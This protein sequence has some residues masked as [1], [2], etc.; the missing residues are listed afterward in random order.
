MG[1]EISSGWSAGRVVGG[2][3]SVRPTSARSSLRIALVGV[4]L[5]SATA[6]G[7]ERVTLENGRSVEGT[8]VRET[9]TR[10]RLRTDRGEFW[11]NKSEIASIE[12]VDEPAKTPAR[13]TTTDAVLLRGTQ[14][15]AKKPAGAEQKAPGSVAAAARQGGA[16]AEDILRDMSSTR[17]AVRRA[18]AYRMVRSWPDSSTTLAAVLEHGSDEARTEATRLLSRPDVGTARE[19]RKLVRQRLR[20]PH[21]AV[22]KLA[23]RAVGARKHSRLEA[24][25]LQLLD[26]DPDEAVR[27]EA[28]RAVV[29]IGAEKTV[30][31]VIAAW[32]SETRRDRRRVY[33]GILVTVF[34]ADLGG[35]AKAWWKAFDDVF[36]GDRMLVDPSRRLPLERGM[37]GQAVQEGSVRGRGQ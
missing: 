18:A 15:D 22:R 3:A 34:G 11:L 17:R 27:L 30:G 19:N 35:D 23:L 4:L 26:D 1:F 33:R 24:D 21:A 32:S 12:A 7:A 25:A 20:D 36:A 9:P 10:V 14:L 16:V 31:H 28:A 29:R 6:L 8:V 5:L 2:P 13:T 37:Q